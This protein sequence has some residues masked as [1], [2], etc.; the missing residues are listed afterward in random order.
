MSILGEACIPAYGANL[1]EAETLFFL[2]RFP[3]VHYGQKPDPMLEPA[4]SADQLQTL[5][6]CRSHFGP[7]TR[8]ARRF[9][10]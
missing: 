3:F 9:P 1:G 4:L 10:Y 8:Q 7:A 2:L 6:E 5:V